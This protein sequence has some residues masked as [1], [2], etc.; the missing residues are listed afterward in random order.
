MVE[1]FWCSPCHK[2]VSGPSAAAC[3]GHSH[4]LRLIGAVEHVD[5]VV[6][7]RRHTLDPSKVGFYNM[8]GHSQG[9]S[10]AQQEA[11]T[12]SRI[13]Q[14]RQADIKAQRENKISLK[15]RDNPQR[16][17]AIPSAL[18]FSLKRQYGQD[19]LQKAK[20]LMQREGLYWGAS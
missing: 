5:V 10:V 1:R 12:R 11:H 17:G 16:V 2:A 6:A 19:Y 4:A 14:M 18:L 7:D 3:Q 13:E 15:G 9:R 20:E 8:V